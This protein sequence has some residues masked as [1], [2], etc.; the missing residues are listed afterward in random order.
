M[1]LFL[2]EI[3]NNKQST[4][5]KCVKAAEDIEIKS[6][7]DKLIIFN[8]DAERYETFKKLYSNYCYS[9][10]QAKLVLQTFLHDREKFDASKL[11]YY[12]CTDSQNYLSI[13]DVFSYKQTE[14]ELKDF[15]EKQR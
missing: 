7:T 12:Y 14:S 5:N 2:L 1:T 11:L 10:A 4:I 15:A 6:F 3:K 9:S 13:S 8:N